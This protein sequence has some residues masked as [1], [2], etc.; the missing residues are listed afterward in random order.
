MK[1]LLASV[2]ALLF[3][4]ALAAC[5]TPPTPA[6]APLPPASP[7]G[8]AVAGDAGVDADYSWLIIRLG[9]HARPGSARDIGSHF[10]K[11]F[12]EERLPGSEVHIF[13]A[14]QLGTGPEQMQQLQLGALEI[15]VHPSTFLGGIQPL[16]SILDV[17]W[18][19]PTDFDDLM[20]LYHESAAGEA[21]KATTLEVGIRT[22]TIWHD[23]YSHWTAN[24]PLASLEDFNG[25][26]VRVM[27]SPMR[28]AMTDRLGGTAINMDW[29]EVYNAML[30]GA[31]DS[32]ENPLAIITD[33]RIHEVQSDLTFTNHNTL[34]QFFMVSEIW[35]QGLPEH[36]QDTIIEGAFLGKPVAAAEVVRLD[37][38]AI[39]MMEEEGM[40]FHTLPEAELQRWKEATYLV[41]QDFVDAFGEPAAE[42]L[43]I[44]EQEID[45]I[46]NR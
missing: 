23:G 41:R 26:V 10:F 6:S 5:S 44:F 22:L 12:I 2:T 21:L 38:E 31:V 7:A 3:I 45:R 13:P 42:L 40:S 37:I 18:L 8:A 20:E 17:P 1:N 9:H 4:L 32:H 46:T 43:A 39:D 14:G 19:L 30:T 33:A 24:R 16:T 25:L 36:V 15:G 34:E 29:G 11:D 27:P 28:I 35:W